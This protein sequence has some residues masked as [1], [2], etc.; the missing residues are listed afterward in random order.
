MR[1]GGMPGKPALR[2]LSHRTGRISIPA[3]VPPIPATACSDRG[4][5]PDP[6]TSQGE[7]ILDLWR[8]LLGAGVALGALVT[9]LI[10]WSVV[11]YRRPR[12]ASPEDLPEQTRANVP[13]EV[14]Y[15]V[16]PL[17]IVVV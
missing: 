14:L 1:R 7:D 10:L 8:I 2:R 11:R 5:A 15:T 3:G 9:A 4:G 6:A 17:I 16:I 13:V 12:D